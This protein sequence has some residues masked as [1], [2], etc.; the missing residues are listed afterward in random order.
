MQNATF[1]PPLH[2]AG[3]PITL[4]VTRM[5]GL[6]CNHFVEEGELKMVEMTSEEETAS[7]LLGGG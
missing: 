1:S 4:L 2:H 3:W 5:E 7:E 6:T